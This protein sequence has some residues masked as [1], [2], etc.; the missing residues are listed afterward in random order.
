MDGDTLALHWYIAGKAEFRAW[1]PH[2]NQVKHESFAEVARLYDYVQMNAME[3]ALLDPHVADLEKLA[4]RLRWLLEEKVE[5]AITNGGDG[6]GLLWAQDNGR[7]GWHKIRPEQVRVLSDVGA[8]DTWGSAYLISRRFFAE[9][10]ANACAWAGQTVARSISG[11]P[12]VPT[13]VSAKFVNR[14]WAETAL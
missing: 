12:L 8:G 7:F 3:A 1:F 5:F 14:S 11:Q 4:L 10:A 9:N 6:E 13:Q 2:P